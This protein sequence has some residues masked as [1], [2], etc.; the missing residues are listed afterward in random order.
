MN[1]CPLKSSTLTVALYRKCHELTRA[2]YYHVTSLVFFLLCSLSSLHCALIHSP[3]HTHTRTCTHPQSLGT[4]AVAQ[5]KQRIKAEAFLLDRNKSVARSA[6][7][8]KMLTISPVSSPCPGGICTQGHREQPR[9]PPA[10][11]EGFL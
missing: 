4:A 7:G 2:F 8:K 3:Q 6:W 9:K 11:K 5:A 1:P 10:P